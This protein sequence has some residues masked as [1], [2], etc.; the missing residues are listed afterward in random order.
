MAKSYRSDELVQKKFEGEIR[1]LKNASKPERVKCPTAGCECTY[2]LYGCNPSNRQANI[3]ILE[4]RIQR[5]HP[6]HTSE[7]LA[8]N[9]FRRPRAPGRGHP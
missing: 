4:E 2:D 1:Q 9:Q 5:E 8:V 6:S 3:S 7:L